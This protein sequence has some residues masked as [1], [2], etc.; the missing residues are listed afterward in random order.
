MLIQQMVVL[1]NIPVVEIG[2]SEIEQ[3]IKK[4]CKIENGKVKTIFT[5]TNGVLHRTIYPQYPERLYQ[6]VQEQQYDQVCDEF[7]LHPYVTVYFL[8]IDKKG[9]LLSGK[10][11]KNSRKFISFSF[12]LGIIK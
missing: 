6:Q 8:R 1:C 10:R 12:R 2:D 3:Y 5:R 7:F 4:E 11:F 9:I